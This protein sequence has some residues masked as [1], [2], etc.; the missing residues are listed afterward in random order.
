MASAT[1]YLALLSL[2]VSCVPGLYWI[3]TSILRF[4]KS[5][6]HKLDQHSDTPLPSHQRVAR[7]TYSLDEHPASPFSIPHYTVGNRSC[8]T[9]N[10]VQRFPR[11]HVLVPDHEIQAVWLST[12][13]LG[14]RSPQAQTGNSSGQE[15][16]RNEIGE[17]EALNPRVEE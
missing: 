11:Y 17:L 5:R 9:S 3:F 14:R 1:I 8:Q 4:R 12:T 16:S 6:K 2:L 10:T 13:S 7:T 15:S